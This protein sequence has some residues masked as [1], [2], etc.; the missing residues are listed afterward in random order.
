MESTAS[1]FESMNSIGKMSNQFHKKEY[2]VFEDDGFSN[3]FME[4]SSR[5]EDE[6]LKPSQDLV[7]PTFKNSASPQKQ[8]SISD[9]SQFQI[10]ISNSPSPKEK[11][12]GV[13]EELTENAKRNMLETSS[14]ISSASRK[15]LKMQD[16]SPDSLDSKTFI[17]TLQEHNISN[18]K[19]IL[20]K[21]SSESPVDMNNIP[22]I[23]S[24]SF[25]DFNI[26]TLYKRFNIDENAAFQSDID[27][28]MNHCNT[29]FSL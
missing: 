24:S 11:L 23:D 25:S 14:E 26:S 9:V 18:N 1:D 3:I 4:S 22:P 29:L 13:L 12:S 28:V 20:V 19:T 7:T 15:S 5:V 6:Y 16:A 17:N 27:L 10:T 21:S 8:S 2:K